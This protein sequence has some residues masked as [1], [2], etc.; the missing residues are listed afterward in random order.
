MARSEQDAKGVRAIR[1]LPI[2]DKEIIRGILST[3]FASCSE[4]ATR[5]GLILGRMKY[6]RLLVLGLVIGRFGRLLFILS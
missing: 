6:S 4:R 5:L 2:D 1:L 3:P